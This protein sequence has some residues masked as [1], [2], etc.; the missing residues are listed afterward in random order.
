MYN[1]ASSSYVKYRPSVNSAEAINNVS[2]FPSENTEQIKS[3][4]ENSLTS[5]GKHGASMIWIDLIL[6]HCPP[7]DRMWKTYPMADCL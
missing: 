7:Y 4:V 1:E 2:P 6:V 5:I 3:I